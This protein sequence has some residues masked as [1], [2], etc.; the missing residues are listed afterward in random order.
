[1]HHRENWRDGKSCLA[2]SATN[3]MLWFAKSHYED[4]F[5]S[6]V[7]YWIVSFGLTTEKY[8]A[9]VLGDCKMAMVLSNFK[10]KKLQ[11]MSLRT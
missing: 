8:Q 10:T 2:L 3:G 5:H 11:N 9:K 1:M 4:C 6:M 7:L